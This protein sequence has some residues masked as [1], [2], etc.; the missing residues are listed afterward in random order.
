MQSWVAH[1]LDPSQS[2][3]E[4][5]TS[6]SMVTEHALPYL[7]A[8]P[9]AAQRSHLLWLHLLLQETLLYTCAELTLADDVVP[10]GVHASGRLLLAG[11][12]PAVAVALPF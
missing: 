10:K 9:P 12:D 1:Q 2:V 11:L 8:T 3:R 6:R 7:T 5:R 4:N